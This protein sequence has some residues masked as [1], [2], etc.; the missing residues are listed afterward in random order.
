M[1]ADDQ[2]RI[3]AFLESADSHE[4]HPVKRIDTHTAFVFLA[5]DRAW[6]LKRAIRYDYVDFSTA[7]RRRTACDREVR[8][9]SP[10]APGLYRG[11]VAVTRRSDG[12]LQ[13]GGTGEPI[14]WLVEMNRFDEEQLFDRL[15]ARRQLDLTLMRPLASAIAHFHAV[16]EPRRDHGG[17]AGM[18]WVV[19]GNAEGFA[20]F[21]GSFLDSLTCRRVT[22]GALAEVER[23]A[24]HLEDRRAAGLVRQCHGDLHLRNIVLLNGYPTLFDAIEFND[25][26]A[27]TDVLY[28]LAFLLMDLWR[29]QL[30]RH[31]NAVWN[32]YLS[33]TGDY[34][35]LEL[36][37][38]FL[39]CR[40]AVRAK[41]SATSARLQS[42]IAL[43]DELESA[44]RDY[45]TMAYRFLHPPGP[46]IVAVGGFSGTGKST[47]AVALA[48]DR[49][50]PPGAVVLRSDEIR[51]RLCGRP[52][53]E[54][55]GPEGYGPQVSRQVY[56]ALIAE[57]VATA[58]AGFSVIVDAVFARPAD[59]R[60]IENAAVEATVPFQGF[61]LEGAEQI[62]AERLRS[63]RAD[64]SDADAHV[65]RMQ[66]TQGAGQITWQRLDASVASSVVLENATS[67]LKGPTNG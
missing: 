47:L 2:Q 53:L 39:S 4:G 18:T 25:E 44:A 31:A 54:P 37:P 51:K 3:V 35:G 42:E 23:W 8:L 11:V 55:L 27:C 64:V 57:A 61:W 49:G 46:S 21:G 43:R 36:L 38:L 60:A 5:G 67:R 62:L 30:P 17:K 33:E 24:G 12:S 59:R 16:A 26:I 66:M 9:N 58:R 63:R 28:D 50:A 10:A 22:E 20:K 7:E 1:I 65:L 41:T 15:A 56:D 19:Q 48:P 34:S 29:R 32:G 13:I 45:L 52:P 40:A 6:K 14:D